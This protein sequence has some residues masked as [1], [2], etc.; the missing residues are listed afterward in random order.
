MVAGMFRF[1]RSL[2]R[3]WGWAETEKVDTASS[4]S[5]RFGSPAWDAAKGV[6]WTWIF[7]P[8]SSGVIG[9]W[10][11][12]EQAL[13]IAV[14]VAFALFVITFVAVRVLP[15]TRYLNCVVVESSGR[16]AHAGA[17][18]PQDG[19]THATSAPHDS[20]ALQPDSVPLKPDVNDAVIFL[21]RA[22]TELALLK[23]VEAVLREVPTLPDD[24]AMPEMTAEQF[25]DT[26]LIVKRFL[27]LSKARLGG[28]GAP[29]RI[30]A[31][32]AEAEARAE[33]YLHMLWGDDLPKAI[34]TYDFRI[35][36]LDV[37][38][39]RRLAEFL[40]NYRTELE[41]RVSQRVHASRTGAGLPK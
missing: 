41:E 32:L 20:T 8:V 17:A 13:P 15:A 9:V 7:P 21:R 11:S 14:A 24:T 36:Y 30:D 40:T 34:G 3:R 27:E 6:F 26:G 28:A 31:V 4:L 12:T 35:F 10:T 2:L 29:P 37:A 23:I 18:F 25:Q 22:Y 39:C 38:V 16:K 19:D 5:E 33:G 1:L